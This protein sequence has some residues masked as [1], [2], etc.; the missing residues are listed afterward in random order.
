MAKIRLSAIK[1]KADRGFISS[2]FTLGAAGP[3]DDLERTVEVRNVADV[4]RELDGF[5]KEIEARARKLGIGAS[6]SVRLMRGE[7]APAGF[8][9]QQWNAYVN[10]DEQ[11]DDDTAAA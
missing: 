7:R 6:C 4:Q 5:A 3:Y 2:T 1:A 9:K 10:L 8:R 11:K